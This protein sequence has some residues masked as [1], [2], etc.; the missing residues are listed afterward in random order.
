VYA[1]WL[2][3]N[4]YEMY[5]EFIRVQIEWVRRD[6]QNKELRRQ[7]EA[8]EE[9]E[10]GDALEP[11]VDA[12]LKRLQELEKKHASWRRLPPNWPSQMGCYERGL[13]YKWVGS[14]SQFLKYGE[15]IWAYGP[16]RA[17]A[18]DGKDTEIERFACSPLLVRIKELALT[19]NSTLDRGGLALARSEHL[20]PGVNLQIFRYGKRISPEAVRELTA[21]FGPE[22][23]D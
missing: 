9:F 13:L 3:E 5:A 21:R 7:A 6:R 19:P 12:L 17:L 23:L 15:E 20:Q 22:T 4:G 11:G 18:I 1:D 8:P 16:V 2:E 14:A 10:F